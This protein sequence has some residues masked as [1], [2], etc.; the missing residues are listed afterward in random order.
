[1]YKHGINVIR[2]DMNNSE[3]LFKSSE[4]CFPQKKKKKTRRESYTL[5]INEY[6][7]ESTTNNEFFHIRGVSYLH[8]LVF[9]RVRCVFRY[10]FGRFSFC[11]L[12][13]RPDR[14]NI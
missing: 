3:W 4:T 12:L 10:G 1:M 8:C 2:R 14:E 6:R 9:H 11:V 7:A 13:D 5:V